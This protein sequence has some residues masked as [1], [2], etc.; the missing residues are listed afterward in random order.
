MLEC[1]GK[2]AEKQKRKIQIINCYHGPPLSPF[3]IISILTI[4]SS[5][6]SSALVSELQ[7]KP[8]SK[9]TQQPNMNIIYFEASENALLKFS[10][11]KNNIWRKHYRQCC[12]TSSLADQTGHFTVYQ[13][14]FSWFWI[15]SGTLMVVPLARYSQ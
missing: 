1:S 8:H 11:K 15:I 14:C 13:I 2:G 4:F 7:L 9:S 12:F 3:M 5:L 6:K 10:M